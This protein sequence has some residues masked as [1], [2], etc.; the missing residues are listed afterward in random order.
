MPKLADRECTS[1]ID[2]IFRFLKQA[3]T[4]LFTDVKTHILKQNNPDIAHPK[5]VICAGEKCSNK[6]KLQVKIFCVGN[7]F[8]KICNKFVI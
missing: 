8:K 2:A 3:I 6:Y 1:T 4:S 5:N 7:C